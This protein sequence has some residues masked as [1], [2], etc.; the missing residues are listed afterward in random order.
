[1]SKKEGDF[2][3]LINEKRG[4]HFRREIRDF[5]PLSAKD[6]EILYNL[7]LNSRMNFTH[8]AELSGLSKQ[9]V[10]YRIKQMEN[11][12]VIRGYQAI[13]NVWVALPTTRSCPRSALPPSRNTWLPRA[14][15]PTVFT[16]K[17]RASPSRL[18]VTP[19]RVTRRPRR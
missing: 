14:S 2:S 3:T 19:A 9:V 4:A 1:M 18:R 6:R 15:K 10:S 16:P 8:L 17:A 12:G 13:P 11:R 5:F 7:S